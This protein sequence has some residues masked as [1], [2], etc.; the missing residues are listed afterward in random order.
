VSSE[1]VQE[2]VK[3]AKELIKMLEST[4]VSRMRLVTGGFKILIERVRAQTG[5]DAPP[6]VASSVPTGDG[7]HR[8]LSP[9]VGTFY[10]SSGPG[11]PSFVEVGSRVGQ[12]QTIG[13]V[14][15]MKVMNEIT[16]DVSGIVLEILVPNGRAV[17]FE[18]PLITIDPKG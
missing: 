9:M 14:E 13:I 11:Q 18:Q 2:A 7:F 8:V 12:G 17:E 4:S 3:E 15:A 5:A 6:S 1:D 16:S 10:H